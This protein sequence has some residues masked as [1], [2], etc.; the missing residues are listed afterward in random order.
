[1]RKGKKKAQIEREWRTQ[2]GKRSTIPI[3]NTQLTSF[4]ED[5]LDF[6]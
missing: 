6:R 2:V 5:A 1:M 3:L 4:I